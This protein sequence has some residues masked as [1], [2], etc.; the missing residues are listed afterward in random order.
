MA[1]RRLPIRVVRI[2]LSGG[3]VPKVTTTI[4]TTTTTTTT[5]VSRRAAREAAG[6][7][8]RTGY[9]HSHL[10]SSDT[11]A[12][13]RQDSPA[14]LAVDGEELDRQRESWLAGWLLLIDNIDRNTGSQFS[15]ITG[16]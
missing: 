3:R 13:R 16:D 7:R 6:R 1:A 9:A 15:Q 10:G 5:T 8:S 11:A 14:W 2:P 4:M 12:N